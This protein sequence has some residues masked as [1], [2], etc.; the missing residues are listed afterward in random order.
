[1]QEIKNIYKYKQRLLFNNETV[2]FSNKEDSMFI[3][4]DRDIPNDLEAVY[5]KTDVHRKQFNTAIEKVPIEVV[6]YGTDRQYGYVSITHR[7]SL[8]TILRDIDLNNIPHPLIKRYINDTMLSEIDHPISPENPIELMLDMFRHIITV[9]R[10]RSLLKPALVRYN[11]VS[12]NRLITGSVLYAKRE[13]LNDL[14]DAIMCVIYYDD[15]TDT[16]RLFNLLIDFFRQVVD[17]MYPHLFKPAFVEATIYATGMTQGTYTLPTVIVP[18]LHRKVH[19]RANIAPSEYVPNITPDSKLGA[20][21]LTYNSNLWVMNTLSGLSRVIF[22]PPEVCEILGVD[23]TENLAFEYPSLLDK[24]MSYIG[25]PHNL[26]NNSYSSDAVCK[27]PM[28]Q[29]YHQI[30]Y[31]SLHLE[32]TIPRL[33][34]TACG[35]IEDDDSLF[36]RFEKDM[37]VDKQAC[38]YVTTCMKFLPY[39]LDILSADSMVGLILNRSQYSRS[40]NY[41]DDKNT[42]SSRDAGKRSGWAIMNS[43]KRRLFGKRSKRKG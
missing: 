21:V 38:F 33:H 19:L 11:N 35:I 1:M 23:I 41:E 12:M 3:T 2:P 16:V 25:H 7:L 42:F 36:D 37:A 40:S 5:Y 18:G 43:L 26:V 22:L 20:Y 24:D 9:L 34:I 29:L 30:L 13:D 27:V 4:T 6:P 10:E 14:S 32:D 31:D 15:P 8:I 17:V 39:K 28:N